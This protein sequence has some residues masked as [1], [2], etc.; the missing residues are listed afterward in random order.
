M[1]HKKQV[2]SAFIE[3]E[4]GALNIRASYPNPPSAGVSFFFNYPSI[5]I[6]IL[7]SCRIK[8]QLALSPC[9]IKY[10]PSSTLQKLNFSIRISLIDSSRY[11]KV[12]C[13]TKESEMIFLS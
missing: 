1:Y 12:K 7:P 5:S 11:E 6:H 9:L 2:F 3:A 4:R 10:S 13:E 8:K